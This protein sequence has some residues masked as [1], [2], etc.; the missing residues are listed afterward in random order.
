[1]RSHEIISKPGS[2]CEPV[3]EAFLQVS[4]VIMIT[5]HMPTLYSTYWQAFDPPGDSA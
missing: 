4:R 2:V 3:C 5:L 1:M